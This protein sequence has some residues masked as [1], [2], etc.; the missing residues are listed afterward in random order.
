MTELRVWVNSNGSDAA[1]MTTF[2]V[3]APTQEKDLARRT[4]ANSGIGTGQWL[5]VGFTPEWASKGQLYLL[6]LN[7]S[8]PGG[9][10]AGYSAKSEYLG[11][12]LLENEIP[13]PHD[14]LFQ[15]GCVAGLQR[16]FTAEK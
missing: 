11:G 10:Q 6:K 4:F 14:I 2:T 8:S 1:G 7:G 15:Y 3:R 16:A 5:S 13:V 12:K 9:M